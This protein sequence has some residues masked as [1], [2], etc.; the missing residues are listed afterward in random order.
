MKSSKHFLSI[1]DLDPEEFLEILS[2]AKKLKPNRRNHE[3]TLREQVG[4]IITT[5]PSLRTRLSFEVG[6]LEL[7]AKALFIRNEEI[8]LGERES[9]ADII[10]VLERYVD[11]LIVRTH[12]HNGLIEMVKHANSSINI[13]NALTSEEHPC[14]AL[15]DFLTLKENFNEFK[16]LK[17]TYIGD[18]NNVCHSLML[19]SS[20]LQVKFTAITPPG[21]EPNLKYINLAI[22]NAKKLSGK[23][24][25]ITNDIQKALDADILYTDV[26]V[27]MGESANNKSQSDFENYKIN[28]ALL[29]NK[30]IPV[31]HCLPA[32][33][34][35][36]I[37]E[38]VFEKNAK[39]IFD[40]AE[41]RLHAQKALMLHLY[42]IR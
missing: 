30:N 15:A 28:E 12:D 5:K 39:L 2:S 27:S 23:E 35:Q 17:L 42:F 34:D 20:L 14:Q 3:R 10:R 21:Y 41:N 38:G 33:K 13:I 4:G 7:G 36:E 19:A 8:G 24:P 6:L 22:Q 16:N 25:Q 37:S 40:Q 9:Y 31:L 1:N 29:K 32:H 18:G 26:W 11:I